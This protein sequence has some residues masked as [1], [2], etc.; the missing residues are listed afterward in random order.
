MKTAEEIFDEIERR[1]KQHLQEYWR[2]RDSGNEPVGIVSC[3]S[4]DPEVLAI[5]RRRSEN[6]FARL[7]ARMAK[8]KE[9]AVLNWLD[10]IKHDKSFGM[11]EIVER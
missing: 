1:N 11:Q 8:R 6:H 4:D 3:V 5:A 2:A 9:L 10:G 7:G